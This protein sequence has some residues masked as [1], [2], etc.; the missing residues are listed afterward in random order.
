[1]YI[2]MVQN[3]ILTEK[4][5]VQCQRHKKQ[6]DKCPVK[7]CHGFSGEGASI[8][9]SAVTDEQERDVL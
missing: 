4:D 7:Q 6:A 5:Y 2:H 8:S 9:A 3:S 1:M